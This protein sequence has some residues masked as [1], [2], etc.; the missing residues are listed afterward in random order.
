MPSVTSQSN[1]SATEQPTIDWLEDVNRYCREEE[2]RSALDSYIA[3]YAE[4]QKNRGEIRRGRRID[5]ARLRRM[6]RSL[7]ATNLVD[8]HLRPR[9]A[10]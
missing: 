6:A 5:L 8:L 7:F 4:Y 2:F 3:D 1:L 10:G 9:R